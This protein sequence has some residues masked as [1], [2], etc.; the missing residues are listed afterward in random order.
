[1]LHSCY[2]K[3]AVA[4]TA[5]LVVSVV[6]LIYIAEIPFSVSDGIVHDSFTMES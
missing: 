6:Y 3:K 2:D 1:M 5:I 4:F